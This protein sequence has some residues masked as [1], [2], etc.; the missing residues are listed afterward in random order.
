MTVFRV[1][2]D[3]FFDNIDDVNTFQT[4]II[5]ILPKVG[6]VIGENSRAVVHIYHHDEVPTGPCTEKSMNGRKLKLFSY[7]SKTYNSNRK[8]K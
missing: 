8:T 6:N 4:A 3:L 2:L 5:S 1:T 7:V